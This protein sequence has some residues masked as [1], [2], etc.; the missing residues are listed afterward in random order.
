MRVR[1]PWLI[2]SFSTTNDAMRFEANCPLEGR[3]IPLPVSLSSGCGL[4]WKSPLSLKMELLEY[5]SKEAVVY[6]QLVELLL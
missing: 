5:L 6:E 4:A 3:L 1:Q 2:V